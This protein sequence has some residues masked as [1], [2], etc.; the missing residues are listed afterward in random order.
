MC[1]ARLRAWVEIIIGI[2]DES[3][4]SDQDGHFTLTTIPPGDY[5]LFAWEDLEFGA[6]NNPDMLRKYE[7]LG[8]PVNVEP[9]GTVNVDV[10]LIPAGR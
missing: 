1:R 3:F 4:S 10:K 2:Q 8:T 9:S 6:Y 5:K 7:N